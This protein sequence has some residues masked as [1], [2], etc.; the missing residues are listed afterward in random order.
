MWEWEAPK[1][2]RVNDLDKTGE[3]AEPCFHTVVLI[4]MYSRYLSFNITEW[5][6][7]Q[8]L[9]SILEE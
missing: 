9:V 4:S 5:L 3:R 2:L 7:D 6:L 1:I 8:C